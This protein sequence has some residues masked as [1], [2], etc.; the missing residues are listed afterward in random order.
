MIAAIVKALRWLFTEP[1]LQEGEF[2]PCPSGWSG[3]QVKQCDCNAGNGC[4]QGR[5]CS[6]LRNRQQE[7]IKRLV[8]AADDDKVLRAGNQKAIADGERTL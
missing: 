3:G 4:N 7:S 6:L 5:S 8:G 1:P 2:E